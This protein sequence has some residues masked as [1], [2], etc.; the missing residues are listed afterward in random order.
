MRL[1]GK[2]FDPRLI[3][4]WPKARCA[5]MGAD[6]ATST[7]LEI[8][9]K[10]LERDGQAVDAARDGTPEATKSKAITSARPT[11]AMGPHAAGSTRFWIPSKPG[12]R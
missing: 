3:F 5:V 7:L 12:R 10:S 6:Q 8:T 2:A 9:V 1:C 4:A 11:S